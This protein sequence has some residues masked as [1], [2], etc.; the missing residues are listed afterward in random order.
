MRVLATHG[1]SGDADVPYASMLTLL[2][3]VSDRITELP[4]PERDSLYA[5]LDLRAADVDERAARTGLWRLLTATRR[6]APVA[7]HRRRQRPDGRRQ[8]RRAR[9]CPGT[10]GRPAG[11]RVGRRP[12]PQG[13]QSARRHRRR[14]HRA[15]RARRRSARPVSAVHRAG[16]RLGRAAHG[17]LRR[18]QRGGGDPTGAVPDRR[19]ARRPHG[20]AAG[21]EPAGRSDPHPRSPARAAQPRRPRRPRRDRRR[22]DR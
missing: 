5:A 15:R 19:P 8:P 9:L 17:R 6:G 14:G 18:R 10:D 20:V 1:R 13:E 21:A 2:H 11:G 3:P 12:L 16:D 22:H 4:N 7:H